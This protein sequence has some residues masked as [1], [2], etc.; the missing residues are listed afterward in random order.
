MS[1]D[2]V[3][4]LSQTSSEDLGDPLRGDNISAWDAE[5]RALHPSADLERGPGVPSPRGQHYRL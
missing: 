5:R 3:P 2:A 4:T 1:T